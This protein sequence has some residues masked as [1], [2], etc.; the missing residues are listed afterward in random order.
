MCVPIF[1]E[2]QVDFGISYSPWLPECTDPSSSPLFADVLLISDIHLGWSFSP[3]RSRVSSYPL[4]LPVF[5]V[6][7]A[8]CEP[9]QCGKDSYNPFT[10][11]LQLLSVG[12]LLVGT[13]QA[14]AALSKCSVRPGL[15]P[16]PPALAVGPAT[17]FQLLPG[18][19]DVVGATGAGPLV[20]CFGFP[21]LTL[22]LT[23]YFASPW[24]SVL[25]FPL[26]SKPA[27][28]FWG[29]LWNSLLGSPSAYEV[30]L[31]SLS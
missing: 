20:E 15:G 16:I 30:R 2:P 5:C 18:P 12:Q 13:P 8:V 10:W 26:L 31:L 11:I 4:V 1:I 25:A 27:C 9:L 24:C 14:P 29:L 7:L 3:V 17:P 21:R 28:S 6:T 22:K 23:C 19:S